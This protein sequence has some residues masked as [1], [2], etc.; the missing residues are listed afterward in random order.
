M[1]ANL[2]G[3]LTAD[4][5][6]Q[7]GAQY[8]SKA[9]PLSLA[10]DGVHRIPVVALCLRAGETDEAEDPPDEREGDERPSRGLD[11]LCDRRHSVVGLMGT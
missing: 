1:R 10:I 11:L 4:A 7:I 3:S 8:A 2:S 6:G 9:S 5:S